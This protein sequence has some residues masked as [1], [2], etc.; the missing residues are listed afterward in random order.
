MPDIVAKPSRIGINAPKGLDEAAGFVD[1]MKPALDRARALLGGTDAMRAAREEFLPRF[2]GETE[3][4]YQW[5]LKVAVLNNFFEAM[6][7]QMVGKMFEKAITWEKPSAIDKDILAN[8]DRRGSDLNAFAAQ[9]AKALLTKGRPHILVDQPKKPEGVETLADER[10]AGLR[11]YWIAMEPEA[12]FSAFADT[13]DGDEKLGQIRWRENGQELD[14]YAITNVQRIRVLAR[15]KLTGNVR[16]EV[17]ERRR[18]SDQYQLKEEGEFIAAGAQ[19]MREIPFVTLYSDRQAFFVSK[20]TMDDIAHKNIEH[21]QSSADQRHILTVS[22][23]PIMF[24]LGTTGPVALVGPYTMFHT[25]ASKND[26]QIGYAE[27]EGKGAEQG[28]KDLDRIVAEGEAMGVRIVTSDAAKTESGEQIDYAKEGSPLQRQAVELERALNQALIYTARWLGLTDEQ[29][30]KVK[31]HK[32]FGMTGDA[33]KAIDQLQKMRDGGDLTQ[34][35][36][37]AESQERGLFKS[38][39]DPKKERAA[40]DDEADRD[41]QRQMA[42]APPPADESTPPTRTAAAA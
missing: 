13:E 39:F 35:T 42:L 36:L 31:V 34:E 3:D 24:Q 38:K 14:G 1:V 27:C 9:L 21:W 23:F 25:Q 7:G 17:W 20:P 18:E 41:L 22:R 4:L 30:G 6:S 2:P 15:D 28:W 8:I 26:A 11:P 37:W 29:A 32:D 33:A 40:L 5:R 10:A 16:F 12:V 19:P